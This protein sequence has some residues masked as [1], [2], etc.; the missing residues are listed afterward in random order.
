MTRQ[1]FL[2]RS[3]FLAI[4]LCLGVVNSNRFI[5]WTGDKMVSTYFVSQLIRHFSTTRKNSNEV[6]R[7]IFFLLQKSLRHD[8]GVY[9]AK[10]CRNQ[11]RVQVRQKSDGEKWEQQS[12]LIDTKPKCEWAPDMAQQRRMREA[13]VLSLHS[14]LRSTVGTKTIRYEYKMPKLNIV[15]YELMTQ[16][17]TAKTLES[18]RIHHTQKKKKMFPIG[19]QSDR[20]PSPVMRLKRDVVEN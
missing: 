15:S 14:D 10:G 4:I 2:P 5:Y 19:A 8:A 16:W 6:R 12:W 11:Y 18:R 13:R 9:T 20:N 7:F 3:I 1:G 17:L